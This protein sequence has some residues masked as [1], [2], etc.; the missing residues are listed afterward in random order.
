MNGE[1]RRAKDPSPP[2]SV[3]SNAEGSHGTPAA[4]QPSSPTVAGESTR[5]QWIRLG[6][7]SGERAKPPLPSSSSLA[8]P[9]LLLCPWPCLFFFARGLASSSLPTLRLGVVQ[10]EVGVA[11]GE[12]GRG[13][14][15]KERPGIGEGGAG[16]VVNF[17]IWIG[18]RSTR[19]Q[20]LSE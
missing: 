5:R 4:I 3:A 1:R 14:R 18:K 9:P 10:S 7:G 17:W 19:E 11:P 6:W 13:P 2:S 20:G 8:V 15:V 16:S 12:D